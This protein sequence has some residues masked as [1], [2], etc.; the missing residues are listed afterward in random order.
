M[1]LSSLVSGLPDRNSVTFCTVVA[2]ML[3]RASWVR[4]AEW[5]VTSTCR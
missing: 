1:T 4:K 2:P 3:A 5:G